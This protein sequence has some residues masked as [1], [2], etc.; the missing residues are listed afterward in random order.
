M[1]HRMPELR[2]LIDGLALGLDALV[3]S[4]WGSDSSAFADTTVR[5]LERRGYEVIHVLGTTRRAAT[6]FG[7]LR[8][9]I[10]DLFR[11]SSDP[12]TVVD[13]LSSRILESPRPVLV[14]ENADLVDPLSLEVLHDA[15]ERTGCRQ[16]ILLSEV[17]VSDTS[18]LVR[19][20]VQVIALD[21]PPY[22]AIEDL[23]RAN[24]AADV[25][26]AW[27]R[28]AFVDSGGSPEIIAAILADAAPTSEVPASLGTESVLAVV[29]SRL[30]ELPPV[31]HSCLR[32][33]ALE[34]GLGLRAG[35]D[36][37]GAIALESL[38]RAGLV[39]VSRGDSGA[40]LS[41][42]PLIT[43]YFT[44]AGGSVADPDHVDIREVDLDHP[45]SVQQLARVLDDR[46][47]ESL[48]V[49]TAEG[50]ETSTP[51]RRRALADALWLVEAS[52]ARIAEA[53]GADEGDDLDLAAFRAHWHAS[54]GRLDDARAALAHLRDLPEPLVCLA[55]SEALLLEVQYAAVPEDLAA[56]A[57]RCLPADERERRVES[58]SA[59]AL[60]FVYAGLLEDARA[61]LPVRPPD[62]GRHAMRWHLAQGMIAIATSDLARADEFV[63][64]GL[65]D[66]VAHED[67][68]LIQ[69]YGYLGVV[70]RLLRGRWGAAGSLLSGVRSLGRASVFASPLHRALRGTH[71]IVLAA[72]GK[73]PL[74]R[75]LALETQGM[76]GS[77]PLAT[78]GDALL[79]LVN[80]FTQ[81]DAT[82]LAGSFATLADDVETRGYG[83]AA[84]CYRAVSIALEPARA[85]TVAPP[86]GRA[87]AW[88]G[89][90]HLSALAMSLATEDVKG[91]R[92]LAA[93]AQDDGFQFLAYLVLGQ[94]VASILRLPE[95]SPAARELAEFLGDRLAVSTTGLA[96]TPNPFGERIS[97][98]E[99]EVALLAATLSNAEIARRL[100][101]SKRTIDHHIS[102]ALRKTGA[103]TRVE[104]N[105]LVRESIVSIADASTAR[106]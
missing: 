3:R 55:A 15:V 32:G 88:S 49:A 34:P 52:D 4:H 86:H 42:P 26:D 99:R 85:L 7:A 84:E 92:A 71:A 23:V 56:R 105:A 48:R 63:D 82:L 16:V 2:Q 93:D 27:V 11:G 100:G 35:I 18:P 24:S 104:L 81:R 44:S 41:C 53:L 30:A 103:H 46:A 9:S 106:R 50:Q 8:F 58:A 73:E 5:E 19:P 83:L 59:L 10:E 17:P 77:G 28:R 74:A 13:R 51:P 43:A 101:V 69:T 33:I 67:R 65:A 40:V 98:R 76:T 39:T 68:E 60:A 20:P 21:P 38:E 6:Q 96:T 14:V 1:P 12:I 97:D 66:A 89:W 57:A 94:A 47:R 90:A 72:D 54:Q 80:G 79:D 45:Q 36:R 25:P 78:A 64:R 29:G 22:S 37:F 61:V 75:R 87:A 62:S 70:I 95:P 91:A 102:N 31:L